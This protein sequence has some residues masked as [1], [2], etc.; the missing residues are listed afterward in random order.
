MGK[1]KAAF[2]RSR[3]SMS[4]TASCILHTS[5]G[6]WKLVGLLLTCLGILQSGLIIELNRDA[7]TLRLT[8]ENSAASRL[9]PH[10][11]PEPIKPAGGT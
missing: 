2:T 11:S 5:K 4:H 9:G 3:P 7:T 1:R 8:A 6:Y 10:R